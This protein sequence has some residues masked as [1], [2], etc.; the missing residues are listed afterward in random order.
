MDEFIPTVSA[1]V[2]EL[3]CARQCTRKCK[4]SIEKHQVPPFPVAYDLVGGDKVTLRLMIHPGVMNAVKQSSCK[5]EGVDF[6]SYVELARGLSA[7]KGEK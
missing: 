4:H 5:E 1:C 7:K 2:K 3:L 6:A